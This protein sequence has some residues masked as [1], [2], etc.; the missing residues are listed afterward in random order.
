[1]AKALVLTVG[2]SV[3]S[4]VFAIQ[5]VQPDFVAF[6]VSPDSHAKVDDIAEQTDLK[7][8]QMHIET[9]ADDPAA[10]GQLVLAF[11]RAHRWA[12]SQVGPNGQVY[13]NPTAGRKWMSTGLTL[14]ASRL[15]ASL[16]YVDVAFQDGKPNPSTMRLVELGNPDDA[17]GG[18]AATPAVALFNRGD[19]AGAAE[20]FHRLKPSH[21]AH[22][23]LYQGLGR[24]AAALGDWDRF[25]HLAEPKVADRLA[26]AAA[27]VRQAADELGLT[28]V[29]DWCSQIDRLSR[30]IL[31]MPRFEGN[32]PP[33]REIIGDL[34]ANAR[35]RIRSA[36]Y[37]DA[38]ARLYRALEG[39]GQLLLAQRGIR[40]G[41]VPW[42]DLPPDAVARFRAGRRNPDAP[43]PDK[44]GLTDAFGLA[45]A[46]ACDGAD[47]FFDEGG[48]VFQND[49]EI[50]N[51]SVLAHGLTPVG[52][53]AAEK[54]A[55]RLDERLRGLGIQTS[56]WQVPNLPDL[57]G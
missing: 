4:E 43:L 9:V 27:D 15:D 57:A 33:S 11:H 48:F 45:R 2:M 54:F 22:R 31:E 13:V 40:T 49:I 38:A 41:A 34:L 14:A 55:E 37:D 28:K 51:Q 23:L 6:L 52:K 26:E 39:V 20:A 12:A 46:L 47:L 42:S 16:V 5:S 1:M 50:R 25:S 53:K 29:V 3:A 35:R 36:R 30:A 32:H 8:S 19:Y 44:I 18:L 7:P 24:T 56:T 21:S 10:L 17:T